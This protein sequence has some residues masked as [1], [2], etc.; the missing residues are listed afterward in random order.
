MRVFFTV[1]VVTLWMAGHAPAEAF[2]EL[3]AKVSLPPMAK[4]AAKPVGYKWIALKNGEDE[5]VVTKIAEKGSLETWKNSTG[6]SYTRPTGEIFASSV[7]WSFCGGSDGTQDIKVEGVIWPLEV[8]RKWSEEISG[9]S[10]RGRSWSKTNTCT[11]EAQVRVKVKVGEFD[12]Y[13]VV[14]KDTWNTRTKYVSPV[15]SVTVYYVR[16]HSSRGGTYELVRQEF[17]K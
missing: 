12:T 11:V 4:P 7:K 10:D 17:P 8:G 2:E 14:C 9:L 15:P 13:K 3:D 1:L 16:E 6:C 5:H